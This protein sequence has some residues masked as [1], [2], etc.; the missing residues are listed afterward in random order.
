MPRT[1]PATIERIAVATESA[2]E[3]VETAAVAA[4]PSIPSNTSVARAATEDNVLNLR[5]INLI[6]VTGTSA[7]RRALVR[8]GNGRFV[9]VE[10]GSALDG[11]QVTAIGDT[12]L[13]F[14]KRGKTYALVL[15]G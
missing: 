5:R 15:P 4:A 8:L 7:D 1:R 12:A 3:A 10:V 6:G 11:G 13:N 9:K 2:P 14:V